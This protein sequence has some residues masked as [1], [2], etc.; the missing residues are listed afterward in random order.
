MP[1]RTFQSIPKPVGLLAKIA[2][3]TLKKNHF[4]TLPQ[5]EYSVEALKIDRKHLT[6][7]NKICGYQDLETLPPLYLGILSMPLQLALMLGEDFP[8]AIVGMVH[9]R[10]TVEQFKPV[11]ATDTIAISVAFGEVTLHEKG[12]AFTFINTAKVGGE[13]VWKS[14]ATYLSRGKSE[15]VVPKSK[16]KAARLVAKAGD[17]QQDFNLPE[18]LGRRYA[19]VS[20]DFN[21]I[22]LHAMTA[23]AFGFKRAIAHG[24]WTK[25][26]SVAAFGDLPP[27]YLLDV[28]FKMPVFLPNKVHLHARTVGK[29]TT[30]ELNNA[31]D[32]K[33][34]LSGTLQVR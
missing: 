8:F 27:A 29:K 7:Y 10:N 9:I 19:A 24:M 5:A 33:P 28:Q 23:K 30:F 32:A 4:K 17:L 31:K 2:L 34:H 11:N 1:N 12:K 6:S 3:S 15:G 16:A 22:H 26:R 13:V 21:L 25:A 18:N 14:V 20:G